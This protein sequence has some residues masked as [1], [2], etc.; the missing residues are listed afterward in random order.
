[1]YRGDLI[2]EGWALLKGQWALLLKFNLVGLYWRFGLE[3]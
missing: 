3:H 1:M 2:G